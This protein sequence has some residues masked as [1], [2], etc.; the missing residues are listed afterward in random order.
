MGKRN[1][2]SIIF[3]FF[4][5]TCLGYLSSF[6]NLD[7]DF[8]WHFRTGALILERGVPKIDWYSYTMP[9]FPWIDHEWLTDIF[10]YKIYSFLG[11][12]FT[13][14]FF[15]ILTSLAFVL[16]IKPK[17]FWDFF[18]PILIGYSA[19]L[20]FLG[21]RPQLLTI[22]FIAVCWEILRKFLD[23]SSRLI[24][25][26]PILF[27]LWT[28]LH[29]G[30]FAG[31]FL[32]FLVLVLEIFKK[33]SLFQKILS[34]KFFNQ[35]TF[36]PHS[37]KQISILFIILILSFLATFIN[38]YG[39]RIYEE[40]FRTIGDGFLRFHIIEWFPLFFTDFFP[41]FTILYLSLFWV[42]FV[43]FYKRI[44]LT[45]LVVSSVFFIFALL[46]QRHFFI[47]VVISIPIF[48]DFIFCLKDSINQFYLRRLFPGFKKWLVFIVFLAI[49]VIGWY[50][51]LSSAFTNKSF[52]DYPEEAIS[53]LRTLPLSDNLFN[54]YGWGGYLIWKLPERKF[55]I[56]GR[57]PSWRQNGEFVFGDY[58]KI[59]E[60]K[61]G[62]QDLLEKYQIK[63]VMLDKKRKTE[64]EKTQEI[65]LKRENFQFLKKHP[66][67][68]KI[69]GFDFSI[70]NIYQELINQGWKIIYE[71]EITVILEKP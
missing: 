71:D 5:L 24:Y 63:I 38:P 30:F 42:F 59:I 69:L 4:I 1:I 3:L 20:G 62:F 32:L 45:Y 10:L 8:G 53:F 58:I 17:R 9:N 48:A 27:I 64:A 29:G 56:D 37:F 36:Q 21:I 7:P 40:V 15:I 26:Y 44:D 31:L 49:L 11:K 60:A 18:I 13:L 41:L 23:G 16:L 39:P 25:F 35:Q 70:K 2:F 22:L 57:M 43:L 55:F 68:A 51:F 66:W 47:F 34:W 52:L 67:F 33:T 28:N 50:P 12:Q 6:Q 61:E 54:E 14:L 19:C 46:S 65:N